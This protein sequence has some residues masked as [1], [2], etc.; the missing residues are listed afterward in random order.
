MGWMNR[1]GR[2]SMVL[3][4]ILA[5]V[6]CSEAQKGTESN[7]CRAVIDWID[8]LMINDI[9]YHQ[10]YDGTKAITTEQLGNKVGEVAYMLDDH[11]CTDYV[12][13]NGDAAYLPV[14]TVIYE[15]KG[16]KSEFRVVA[17]NK[18]YEVAHNPNAKTVGE[19]LDIE[20]KVAKVALE[21]G[22]DG[23]PIG[24]FSEKA[25]SEFVRE[26]LPLSYVGYNAVYEKI[27]HESGVFL[28]VHLE[29]GTSF[30]MV[31]YPKANAF[32]A[33]AFGTERLNELI[34]EQRKQIKAAAG[35]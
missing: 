33:G 23:S 29:D 21:S 12:S 25:S 14:G 16:Y 15:L 1:M 24:D 7:G 6:G 19:L 3:L 9:K 27:K 32:S 5:L 13:K 30:R 4:F 11:A 8:F 10:K 34:M 28:R 26:L 22:N 17:D 20:G 35:M 31:Y 2:T 18:I